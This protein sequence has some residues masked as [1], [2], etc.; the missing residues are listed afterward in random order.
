MIIFGARADIALVVND[1]FGGNAGDTPAAPAASAAPAA[2][3]PVLATAGYDGTRPGL[4]TFS[5]DAG[6]VIT[7]IHWSTWGPES[8]YGTGTS[9]IQGCVPNCAYG[10]ETPYTTTVTLTAPAAGRFTRV[11]AV[12][13]GQVTSGPVSLITGVQQDGSTAAAPASPP[14]APAP[15]SGD[16]VAGSGTGPACTTVAGYYPGGEPGHVDSTGFCVPD[17]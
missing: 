17:K 2:P 13:D 16:P 5:G 9:N 14:P 12:R 4:I 10:S 7:G 15:L 1:S 8:A 3:V 11:T 6:Y